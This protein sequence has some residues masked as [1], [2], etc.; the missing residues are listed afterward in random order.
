M[1][2]VISQLP[3]LS[4]LEGK[5]TLTKKRSYSTNPHGCQ[6]LQLRPRSSGQFQDVL[7][8]LVA[9]V[10]RISEVLRALQDGFQRP[11]KT[12]F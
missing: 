8:V 4:T 10:G 2:P 5:L 3:H 7:S 12:L 11:R 9:G 6:L 1:L